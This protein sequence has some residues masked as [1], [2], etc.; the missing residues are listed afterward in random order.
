MSEIMAKKAENAGLIKMFEIKN[1]P[2][3]VKRPLFFIRRKEIELSDQKKNFW[4]Y[5]IQKSKKK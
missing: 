1:H 5:I 3:I 2:V 4:N